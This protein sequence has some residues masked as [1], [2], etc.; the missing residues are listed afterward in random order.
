MGQPSDGKANG[1][2]RASS[3]ETLERATGAGPTMRPIATVIVLQIVF[4]VLA[5][6]IVMAYTRRR[7]YR[8]D[9]GA[10]ILA[11]RHRMIDALC[12]LQRVEGEALPS[13]LGAFGIHDG[14]ARGWVQRLHRRARMSLQTR[15]LNPEFSPDVRLPNKR[16]GICALRSCRNPRAMSE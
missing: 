15:L 9:A 8:A 6:L 10:A 12:H 14:F 3:T 13:Q 1:R 5:T 4:G 2:P 16:A 7:E 11:G